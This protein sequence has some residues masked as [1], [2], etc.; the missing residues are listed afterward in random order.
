M[1]L[2][3]HSTA[4]LGLSVLGANLAIAEV[5]AAEAATQLSVAAPWTVM[6]TKKDVRRVDPQG[7][8]IELAVSE[9]SPIQIGVGPT[10]VPL[11]RSATAG[12]FA[13]SIRSLS[14]SEQVYLVL[15]GINANTLPGITYNLFLDLPDAAAS[16]GPAD[17]HYVG[18][19][20]FFDLGSSRT[21][22]FNVTGVIR[23]FEATGLLDDHPTVTI[24]PAGV[25]EG[26]AK[27]TIDKVLLVAVGP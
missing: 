25:P 2:L 16:S 3:V 18:T 23:T 10:L 9:N 8:D 1:C 5:A 12:T 22:V 26:E 11:S 24:I 13:Q 7:K 19:M 4:I 27:P 20:N 21:V 14:P 6:G 15:H 17:P